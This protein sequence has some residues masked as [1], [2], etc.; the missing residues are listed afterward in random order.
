[1]AQKPRGVIFG[2]G[3]ARRIA[4]AVKRV[5]S[6]PVLPGGAGPGGP[7][8]WNPGLLEGVVTSPISA[9]GPSTYGTGQV[10]IQ[11][12]NGSGAPIDD[13]AYPDPVDV[14]NYFT[15]TGTIAVDTRVQIAWR[16]GGWRYAGGDCS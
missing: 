7:R 4:S 1:L 5:E 3:A 14:L 10:Q 15:Q 8:L 6:S 2:E 16:N 12:D 11:T 13:P 9:G